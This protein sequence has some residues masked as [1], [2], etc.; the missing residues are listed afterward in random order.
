MSA[1]GVGT[2][3]L[4]F[5][6]FGSACGLAVISGGLSLVVPMFVPLTATLAALAVAGW[7]S[8]HRSGRMRVG[9]SLVLA[10]TYGAPFV[11]LSVGAVVFLDPP[12]SLGAYR[13]LLLG[14]ALVPLWAAERARRSGVRWLERGR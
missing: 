10:V 4:G 6:A 8:I 2:G 12:G 11:A 14:V 9:R 13:G 1:P 7:A 5:D 3:E